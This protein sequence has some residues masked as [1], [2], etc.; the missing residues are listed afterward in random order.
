MTRQ[1]RS[2]TPHARL[3]LTSKASVKDAKR[4]HDQ[5]VE[6]LESAPEGVRRWARDRI[7]AA[8]DAYAAIADPAKA[9]RGKVNG[10]L[11]LRRAVAGVVT[12]AAAVAVVVG[13]YDLGG[14]KSGSSPSQANASPERPSLSRGDQ[15]RLAQLMRKLKANPNDTKTLVAVG[16]LYFGA[17]QFNVAGSFMQRALT[18]EP[19]EVG[20]RLALGAS[21]FNLNDV[22]D[23]RRDWQRVIAADPKNVEAYYDLGF[24][25]VSQDPPDMA[26]TKEMWS[27][28]VELDPNSQVA[29]SVSTHLEGLEKANST[30]ASSSGSEG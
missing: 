22:A 1:P 20:A 8:D 3:G 11:R 26:K 24:L 16:N 19:N 6:F 10:N 4:A 25:Y 18:V 28:V 9:R 21:E 2:R 17:R 14:G 30:G 5:V 29:K 13:V 15:E 7:A 23:A 27:K 12:V